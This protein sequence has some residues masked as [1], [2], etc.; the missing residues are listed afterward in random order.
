MRQ[1][2]RDLLRGYDLRQL[3]FAVYAVAPVGR[4]SP[5]TRNVMWRCEQR[6]ELF[7]SRYRQ[8]LGNLES[9]DR[10]HRSIASG[11]FVLCRALQSA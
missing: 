6:C 7:R 2:S 4:D 1:A 11:A 3:R 9:I 5:M 10:F 8:D